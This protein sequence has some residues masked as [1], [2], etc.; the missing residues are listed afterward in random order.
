MRHDG[1]TLGSRYLI[2]QSE[3]LSIP[4]CF[5]SFHIVRVVVVVRVES[6]IEA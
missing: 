3:S 5:V 1:K 2:K 4:N 6:T